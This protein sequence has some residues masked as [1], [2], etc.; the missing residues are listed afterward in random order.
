MRLHKAVYGQRELVEAWLLP[1]H[2][3]GDRLNFWEG[4]GNVIFPEVNFPGDH[5]DGG[6]LV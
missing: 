3:V 6:Y 2:S 1:P 4:G 5:G